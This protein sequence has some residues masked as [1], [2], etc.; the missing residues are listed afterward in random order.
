M[1]EE[2]KKQLD[3]LSMRPRFDRKMKVVE[4]RVYLENDVSL[5]RRIR[6]EEGVIEYRD[7]PE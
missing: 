3:E 2:T 1:D 7:K 6:G 5:R 4:G